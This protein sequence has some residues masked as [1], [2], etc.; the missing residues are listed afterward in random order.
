MNIEEFTVTAGDQQLRCTLAVPE[1]SLVN[2]H[3]GLLLNISATAQFALYDETQ[4]HPT[5][6][7]LRA[8]HY[9]LSFDLPNHG[10]RIDAHLAEPIARSG[11]SRS[12]AVA[13]LAITGDSVPVGFLQSGV[14][15]A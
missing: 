4:N 13:G 10:K 2:D 8:G 5:H 11:F 6:P 7:F 12:F 3:S 9:V 15:R 14:S 1:A